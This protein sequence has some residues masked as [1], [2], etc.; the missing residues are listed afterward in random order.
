MAQSHVVSGLIAKRAELAGRIE[1]VQ[2][3]LRSL[4]VTLDNLDATI[5][6]FDPEIDI[7]EIR[8][9]PLPARNTAF[10]GEV[11]RL[12]LTCLRKA[13][14]PLPLQEITL[15]VMTGRSL[16]PDDKPLLRVLAKRVGAALRH[17]RNKGLIVSSIGPNG[18]LLWEIAQKPD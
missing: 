7:V 11:A 18:V 4:I 1:T 16:N 6:L 12:V 3:E 15:H 2:A 5:R 13:T 17:N 8:P 10:R 9:K 14:Q